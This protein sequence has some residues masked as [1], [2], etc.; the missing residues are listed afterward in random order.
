[1]VSEA[2]LV[3]PPEQFPCFL[4]VLVCCCVAGQMVGE[5]EEVQSERVQEGKLQLAY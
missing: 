2:G 5:S 1:M 3:T 4:H